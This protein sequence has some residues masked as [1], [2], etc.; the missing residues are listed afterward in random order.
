MAAYRS[1]PVRWAATVVKTPRPRAMATACQT[2]SFASSTDRR[3]A[4]WRRPRA[5][6][7][8]PRRPR[9]SGRASASEHQRH[10]G[11]GIGPEMRDEVGLDQSRRGLGRGH[12]DVRDRDA[13]E[14]AKDG[15]RARSSRSVLSSRVWRVPASV[16]PSPVLVASRR[17][18]RRF[19]STPPGPGRQPPVRYGH[20]RKRRGGGTS[21]LPWRRAGRNRPGAAPR[22]PPADGRRARPPRRS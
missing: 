14:G 9:S 16:P 11:Q 17:R 1:G 13:Q 5:C 20:G 22:P 8:P 3:P 7:H 10:A 4:P 21:S 2:R 15:P 19:A 18:I 6:L 12:Q